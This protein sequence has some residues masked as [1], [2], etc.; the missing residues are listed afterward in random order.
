MTA[1]LYDLARQ[2]FL[3]GD[4]SWPSDNIKL[5]CVSSA[6][7]PDLTTDEFLSD[8]PGGAILATSS[9]LSSKTS[10]DGVAD[11]ADVTFSAVTGTAVALVL[12]QDT[13][14]SGTSRLI[15]YTDDVTDFPVSLSGAGLIVSWS[16]GA[17]KIFK[18]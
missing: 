17:S 9:N 2:A 12:Y 3:D 1:G 4:L 15:E 11:A 14:V 6:Y 16:S 13:G 8:I 10:T 18:L 5:I 7:T